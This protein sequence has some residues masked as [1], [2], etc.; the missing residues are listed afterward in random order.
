MRDA[1]ASVIGLQ[2]TD[3]LE[4]LKGAGISVKEV[5]R[6]LPPRPRVKGV[7]LFWRVVACRDEKEGVILIVAPEWFPVK[8]AL[9]EGG[10]RD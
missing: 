5:K 6:T 2:E 1:L 10:G 9:Q 8:G 3:A 4:E 7:P